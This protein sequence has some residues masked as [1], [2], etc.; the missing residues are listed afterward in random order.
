MEFAIYVSFAG[1][2]G[3]AS[4]E[5]WQATLP[6]GLQPDLSKFQPAA[7]IVGTGT[8]FN[9]TILSLTVGINGGQNSVYFGIVGQ[10]IDLSTASSSGGS[11]SGGFSTNTA[12]ITVRGAIPIVGW[13][14]TGS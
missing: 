2:S 13:T 14:V 4:T 7:T 11:S 6:S 9:G 8:G 5:Q 10:M 3:S 1:P 12:F